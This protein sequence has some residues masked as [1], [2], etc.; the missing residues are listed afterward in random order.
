MTAIT[1]D[2]TANV[3][4]LKT[5]LAEYLKSH[6]PESETLMGLPVVKTDLF[7]NMTADEWKRLTTAEWV[8]LPREPEA[9]WPSFIQYWVTREWLEDSII[10]PGTL[11]GYNCRCVVLLDEPEF[12]TPE[13]DEWE[14]RE[15]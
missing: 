13:Y 11:F 2:I 6:K 9:I 12:G 14:R 4:R 5:Q 1:I 8:D 10:P 7:P 15:N 3:E